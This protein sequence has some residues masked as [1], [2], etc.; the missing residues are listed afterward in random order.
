MLSAETLMNKG[1]QRNLFLSFVKINQ[2]KNTNSSSFFQGISQV[3][4]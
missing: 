3:K 1:T 2:M 4:N